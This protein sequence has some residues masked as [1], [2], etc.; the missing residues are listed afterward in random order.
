MGEREDELFNESRMNA[1]SNQDSI[2]YY[3]ACNQGGFEPEDSELYNTGAAFVAKNSLKANLEYV[4]YT[5]FLKEVNNQGLIPE[6]TFTQIDAKKRLL[7]KVLGIKNLIVSSNLHMPIGECKSERIGSVFR[8]Y[9]NRANKRVG[10]LEK[11]YLSQIE[12]LN[13]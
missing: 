11:K 6:D 5:S 8:D 9:Y 3:L 13:I 4:K 12:E 10:A 2:K 1:F 7:S